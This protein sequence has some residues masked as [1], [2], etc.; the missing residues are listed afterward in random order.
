[1][2]FRGGL[3]LASSAFLRRALSVG[4]D[5]ES[6][7]V[8]ALLSGIF[9]LS[10]PSGLLSL[11]YRPVSAFNL[12]LVRIRWLCQRLSR[13]NISPSAPSDICVLSGRPDS[14]DFR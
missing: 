10:A 7:E 11:V 4:A 8:P 1:M 3:V 5:P 14:T 13:R 6:E 12:P 9:S 2:A